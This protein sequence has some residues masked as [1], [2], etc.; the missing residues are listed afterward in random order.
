MPDAPPVPEDLSADEKHRLA[1]W[2]RARDYPLGIRTNAAVQEIIDACLD[3]HG[4]RGNKAKIVDW[5]RAVTGWIRRQ[6]QF[7]REKQGVDLDAVQIKGVRED[8]FDRV[9]DL[10]ADVIPMEG[11]R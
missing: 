10:F 1:L 8:D 3:H 7:D 9:G 11:R 2:I 4:A 5:Y 6:Q